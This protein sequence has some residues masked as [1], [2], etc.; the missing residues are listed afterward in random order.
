MKA[1]IDPYA[2]RILAKREAIKAVKAQ[3]ISDG[4]KIYTIPPNVISRRAREYLD[5]HPECWEQ[6]EL[7][8]QRIAW[9]VAQQYRGRAKGVVVPK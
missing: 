8:A 7:L 6:A 9:K 1:P 3:L 4:V 2:I 5:R